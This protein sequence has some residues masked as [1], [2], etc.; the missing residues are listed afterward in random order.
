MTKAYSKLAEKH[1]RFNSLAGA[2]EFGRR[3]RQQLVNGL[4][5][6]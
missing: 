6:G 4:L 1:N 3:D 2:R 5:S